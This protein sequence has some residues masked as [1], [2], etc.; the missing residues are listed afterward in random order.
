MQQ[1]IVLWYVRIGH[2]EYRLTAQVVASHIGR[3]RPAWRGVSPAREHGQKKD[4]KQCACVLLRTDI[5]ERR[6]DDGDRCD[7]P[8]LIPPD[9]RSPSHSAYMKE[10]DHEK[11]F[12]CDSPQTNCG[13][14]SIFR[15]ARANTF[16]YDRIRHDT[17][18]SRADRF[19]R[20]RPAALAAKGAIMN[21]LVP[22]FVALY[23]L[24]GTG[25]SIMASPYF[26]LLFL[27]IGGFIALSMLRH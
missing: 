26:A 4:A 1:V 21:H 5:R 15:I 24:A 19:H 2:R 10:H 12:L 11:R 16:C 27:A 9:F 6:D 22:F 13:R 7:G 23:V 25:L 17:L 8:G 18:H 14:Q 3:R 20:R